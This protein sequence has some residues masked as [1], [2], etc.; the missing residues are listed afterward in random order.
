[1][2]GRVRSHAPTRRH[3]AQALPGR[4]SRGDFFCPSL[5]ISADPWRVATGSV[6]GAKSWPR[7]T[8][9]QRPPLMRWPRR[10]D[11]LLEHHRE[12]IP[13]L[14]FAQAAAL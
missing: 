14:R 1:M 9:P 13:A 5:L 4:C 12:E 3:L 7:A 2:P 11:Y 6:A 10:A 8:A